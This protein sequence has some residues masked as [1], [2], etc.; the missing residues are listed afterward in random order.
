MVWRRG[1]LDAVP[2]NFVTHAWFGTAPTRQGVSQGYGNLVHF[3]AGCHQIYARDGK[4]WLIAAG[5]V[6]KFGGISM[7]GSKNIEWGNQS[8]GSLTCF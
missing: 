3:G 4:L 6:W 2:H 8:V 7:L 5:L 1:K